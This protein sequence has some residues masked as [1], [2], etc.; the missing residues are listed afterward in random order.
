MANLT[1]DLLTEGTATY[2]AVWAK[3]PNFRLGYD[4]YM[5][6]TNNN[7]T[8]QALEKF[9]NETAARYNLD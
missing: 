2:D 5:K 9:T 8:D 1:A 4:V 3:M 6:A 7:C